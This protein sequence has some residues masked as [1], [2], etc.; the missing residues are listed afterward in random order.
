[1][2]G[3]EG[4]EYDLI[5]E[6]RQTMRNCKGC[7]Y[8]GY[9]CSK[10]YFTCDYTYLTGKLRPCSIENCTVRVD[11]KRRKRMTMR[12]KATAVALALI[13]ISTLV[14]PTVSLAEEPTAEEATPVIEVERDADAECLYWRQVS[15]VRRTGRPVNRAKAVALPIPKPTKEE[16]LA[17]FTEEER[18]ALAK[19]LWGEARG[20]PSDMEKA[21]VIWCILNRVDS[22]DPYYPDTI[23]GVVRQK[24]QFHGYSPNHPV[25]DNLLAIVDDVLYRWAT[26]GE[27][28]VLPKEYIFFACNSKG[29]NVFR[30]EFTGGTRWD[31]SLP[32]PYES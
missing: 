6:N 14:F 11:K 5:E 13:V 4:R 1:M 26:D 28:R 18:F 24:G 17:Q 22:E 16:A 3:D 7:Y 8:R 19:C 30:T 32:N 27:G 21:A 15:I 31:W 23:L 9:A 20:I 2:V 29:H 12:L 10:V 25:W